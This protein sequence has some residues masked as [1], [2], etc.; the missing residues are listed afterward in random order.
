[1]E[2]NEQSETDAQPETKR[3]EE[4]NGQPPDVIMCNDS[5]TVVEGKKKLSTVVDEMV[6][7]NL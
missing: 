5:L 3:E 4:T 2:A 6:F 1:M 7:N